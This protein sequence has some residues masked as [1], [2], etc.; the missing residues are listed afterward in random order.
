MIYYQKKVFNSIED[1]I[2]HIRKKRYI[3][4]IE[5]VLKE[6]LVLTD[7]R[8]ELKIKPGFNKNKKD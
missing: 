5:E 3:F 7:K 2:S 8:K 4:D 1:L 6:Y